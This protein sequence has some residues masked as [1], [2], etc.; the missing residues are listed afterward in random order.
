MK[1]ED[2]TGKKFGRFTVI[3]RVNCNI[4]PKVTMW[5][6]KCDCGNIKNVPAGRIK[7]GGAKSCGCIVIENS[8]KLS[9]KNSKRTPRESTAYKIWNDSYNNS[10]D[11]LSFEDF[12]KLSQMDCFYCGAKPSNVQNIANKKSSEYFRNNAKFIYNGIDRLDSQKYHTLNNIVV[13]CKKCNYAKN[14][15]SKEE[16][17][18][19]VKRLYNNFIVDKGGKIS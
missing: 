10:G 2:L 14:D 19:W 1:F 12:L 3:K 7:S 16:F 4:I 13:C 11:D 15:R 8:I 6:C 5:E 17:L 9:K 18:K